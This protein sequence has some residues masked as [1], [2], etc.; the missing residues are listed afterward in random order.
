[1]KNIAYCNSLK[2]NESLNHFGF[3]KY[4]FALAASKLYC[5]DLNAARVC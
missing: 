5:S 1:M 3:R 4:T 2:Y